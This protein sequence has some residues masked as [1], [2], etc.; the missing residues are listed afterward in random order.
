MKWKFKIKTKTTSWL[1][2]IK[3]K[4]IIFHKGKNFNTPVEFI[5]AWIAGLQQYLSSLY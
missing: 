2:Q 4:V 5:S 3:F 1:E